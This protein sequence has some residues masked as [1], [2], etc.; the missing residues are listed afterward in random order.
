ME[1]FTRISHDPSIMGG[2]AC[3]TGTR[4]TVGTILMQISEGTSIV[5]L[6]AEYPH[7]TME[8]IAEALQYVK[9]KLAE[10]EA[11]SGNPDE[12]ISVDELFKEWDIWDSVIV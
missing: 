3:I 7:L 8:D 4:I 10:A 5:E 11:L 6:L 2:K 9:E 12:W 1:K